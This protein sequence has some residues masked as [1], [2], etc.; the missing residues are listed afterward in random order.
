MQQLYVDA[1]D[2]LARLI[3]DQTRH[4]TWS[5]ETGRFCK[6]SGLRKTQTVFFNA[7]DTFLQSHRDKILLDRS[8]QIRVVLYALPA[9]PY[10]KSRNDVIEQLE[11]LAAIQRQSQLKNQRVKLLSAPSWYGSDSSELY[12]LDGGTD[13]MR[14]PRSVLERSPF[15]AGLIHSGMREEQERLVPIDPVRVDGLDHYVHMLESGVPG[16]TLPT[17]CKLYDTCEFF[18]DAVRSKGVVDAAAKLMTAYPDLTV[19]N[20]IQNWDSALAKSLIEIAAAQFE[21]ITRR[22]DFGTLSAVVME[23]LLQ[24]DLLPG[25][26]M[27]ILERLADWARLRGEAADVLFKATPASIPLALHIRLSIDALLEPLT[28]ILGPDLQLDVFA[29]RRLDARVGPDEVRVTYEQREGCLAAICRFENIAQLEVQAAQL[30]VDTPVGPCAH[31]RIG[32]SVWDFQARTRPRDQDS[33]L[34]L[35]LKHIRGS[36]G[37]YHRMIIKTVVWDP[38]NLTD[39]GRYLLKQQ[40]TAWANSDGALEIVLTFAKL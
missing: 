29:G 33:G 12:T 9:H 15:F 19:L 20:G 13:R 2:S 4:L 7:L 1:R 34:T 31:L 38:S 6:A 27:W 10:M 32:D 24:H 18:T 26:E 16:W 35:Q 8:A 22:S 25:P 23:Q 28:A 39:Y 3:Q 37:W 40:W 36:T 14:V 21:T 30:A 17:L 11:S 5:A